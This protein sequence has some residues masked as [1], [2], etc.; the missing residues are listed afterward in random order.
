MRFKQ[1]LKESEQDFLTDHD[2][3]S[4][5]LKRQHVTGYAIKNSNEVDV[6]RN[7]DLSYYELRHFP[8][9]FRKITGDFE[10]SN[11]LLVSL[12][13]APDEVTNDFECYYNQLSSYEFL[14]KKI[15]RNLYLGNDRVTSLV[16]IDWSSLYV[17]EGI[18]LDTARIKR[19][20]LG[21][22]LLKMG[23]HAFLQDIK[24]HIEFGG[25]DYLTAP[26]Q[27]IAKYIG[28]PNDIFDC[29]NELI[30]AGFEEYAQL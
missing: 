18:F 20:G 7:V 29:Q 16:D 1:Y 10:C 19:G 21:L 3:I 25:H 8:I 22:L 9:K 17:E 12:Q 4:A 26:F 14:P 30:E 11:N 5:W 23:P 27:I 13:G 28:K 2:E 6:E 15:G 24:Y